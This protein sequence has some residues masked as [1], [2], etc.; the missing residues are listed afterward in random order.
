MK[1]TEVKEEFIKLRAKNYSFDKIAEEL[2]VAKTTLID[3]QGEFKKEIKNLRAIEKQKLYQQYAMTK[4]AKI[5]AYGGLLERIREEITNRKLDTI[6]TKELIELSLKVSKLLDQEIEDL[7]LIFE[8]DCL[9][10]WPFTTKV[11]I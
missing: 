9:E 4:E 7:E 8:D 1:T 10:E 6:D 11:E 3:W 5:K 2:E